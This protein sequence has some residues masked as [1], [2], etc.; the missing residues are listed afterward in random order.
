MDDWRPHIPETVPGT[1]CLAHASCHTAARS[2]RQAPPR[3]GKADEPLPQRLSTDVL[4]ESSKKAGPQQ[5]PRSPCPLGY[6]GVVWHRYRCRQV[7]A[8]EAVKIHL[9]ELRRFD[10]CDVGVKK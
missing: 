5:S 1:P 2:L 10:H 7:Q 6:R 4:G 8:Q 9:V 3:T